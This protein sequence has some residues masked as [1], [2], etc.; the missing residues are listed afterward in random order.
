MFTV[1]AGIAFPLTLDTIPDRTDIT[2]ESFVVKYSLANSTNVP[3]VSTG[4]TVEKGD[5]AYVHMLTIN[6]V[7]YYTINVLV[8]G[9]G[10]T[11]E[12]DN[13]NISVLVT[14]ATVDDVYDYVAVVDG[15]IDS[16][17]SQVDLLDEAT[18]NGLNS[19]IGQVQTKL[20]DITALISDENDPGITSL[21]ELLQQLSDSV[22]GSNNTLSAIQTYITQA[23]DDIENMIAGTDTLADGSPNPFKGNTNIDI[24]AA[25]SSM[26][27][28]LQQAIDAAKTAVEAKIDAAKAELVDDIAAVQAVV[29][30]NQDLLES[31]V[32]GLAKL[33]TTLEAFKT[34][35]TNHFTS[36]TSDLSAIS[37][38]I[39]TMNAAMSTKLDNIE[40]K[41]DTVT[42]Y[43]KRRQ[44]TRIV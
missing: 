12:D 36:V 44:Q 34:A 6:Q 24:M 2:P 18:L 13:V 33:M 10:S 23:T 15:K 4:T 25:L 5:G 22:G 1:K 40:T 30:A 27:V 8:P 37:T 9:D 7:G 16:I 11:Y 41:I 26:G 28:T 20:A 31:D 19:Q 39:S 35:E 42:S 17:K 43:V 14:N 29:D 32:F 38:A 21:K 3:T